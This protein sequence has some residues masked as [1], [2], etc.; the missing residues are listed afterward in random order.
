[1]YFLIAEVHVSES[2]HI[3]AHCSI[4]ALSDT[5]DPDYQA[6]STHDHNYECGQCNGLTETIEEIEQAIEKTKLN[7]EDLSKGEMHDELAFMTGRAKRDVRA[8][9]GEPRQGKITHP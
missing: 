3:P 6:T 1:M 2:S 9:R 7:P 8:A 4:F 5:Q